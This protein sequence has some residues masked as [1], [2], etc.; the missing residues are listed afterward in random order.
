MKK[1]ISTLFATCFA[2]GVWAQS[3]P[4]LD[5]PIQQC[6]AKNADKV[7]LLPANFSMG[8]WLYKLVEVCDKLKETEGKKGGQFVV[9]LLEFEKELDELLAIADDCPNLLKV[10]PDLQE[11]K[12]IIAER[13]KVEN[14]KVNTGEKKETENVFDEDKD[15]NITTMS[16]PRGAASKI[17]TRAEKVHKMMK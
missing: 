6:I 2:L 14:F 1:T 16:L 9:R 11:I 8:T 4:T 13:Q 7:E 5:R 10:K 15:K 17:K 3:N 12:K